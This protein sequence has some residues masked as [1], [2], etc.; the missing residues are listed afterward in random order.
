M[1]M[2]RPVSVAMP[3]NKP[4]GLAFTITGNGNSQR[5]VIS[6]NDN[7]INETAFVLQRSTERHHLD[8]RRDDPASPL[9]QPNTAM[10]LGRI[11]DATSN[12]N[13]TY[14]YRVVAKNTI[15]YGGQFMSLSADVR[16]RLR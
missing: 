13:T 6:W 15:G 11:T 4:D 5:F 1:D 8:G 2:M 16:A 9:D 10:A 7:S 14:Q 12:V 3:P